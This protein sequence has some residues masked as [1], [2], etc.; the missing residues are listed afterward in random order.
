MRDYLPYIGL[1]LLQMLPVLFGVSVI[2]F[3]LVQLA[4]GDPARTLL[5]LEATPET[6]AALRRQYGLDEPILD[7]YVS[8]LGRLLSGDLGE[9]FFYR[10]P[11][12]ELVLDRV[13]TTAALVVYAVVLSLAISIPAAVVAA[14]RPGT[15]IDKL[16]RT[17]PVLGLAMPTFWVGLLL[18]LVFALQ[19]GIFPVGAT[20]GV[21]VGN[22]L[23]TLFLPALTIAIS[24]SPLLIRSLRTSM[25]DVL[26]ADFVATARAKGLSPGRVVAAHVLRNAAV[27]TVALLGVQTG[28]LIGGTVVVER[29]F[30]INGVGALMLDSVFTRD[31]PV[32][33]GVTIA[34][35]LAVALTALLTDLVLAAIDPRTVER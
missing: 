17:V 20:Q 13:P 26:G 9:S 5:G 6:V 4:P 12:A 30:A 34:L 23:W 19:L 29:V 21:Q 28:W 27:P 1:R 32:V 3:L 16:V 8:F 35:A 15:V 2:S 24:V 14:L 11:T 33:Q 10:R 7:Q 22:A 18:I 25:A 31:F